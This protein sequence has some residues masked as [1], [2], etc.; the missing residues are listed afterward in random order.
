[1][2]NDLLPRAFSFFL[3]AVGATFITYGVNKRREVA[4]GAFGAI[5]LGMALCGLA[6]FLVLRGW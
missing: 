4:V 6:S 1:M 5:I 2:S 3:L